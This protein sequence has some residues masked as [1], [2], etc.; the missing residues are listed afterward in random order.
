MNEINLQKV[1][2]V[3]ETFQFTKSM[4]GLTAYEITTTREESAQKE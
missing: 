1:R 3:N 2:S 4:N